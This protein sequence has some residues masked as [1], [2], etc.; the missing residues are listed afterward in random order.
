MLLLVRFSYHISAFVPRNNHPI[1]Q[2]TTT[3]AASEEAFTAD[4]HFPFPAVVLLACLV[5]ECRLLSTSH[6]GG[7]VEYPPATEW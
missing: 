5:S 1:L 4:M 7:T 6:K 3:T 2:D